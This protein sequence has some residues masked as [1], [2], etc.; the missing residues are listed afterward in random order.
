F[1][2]YDI[3]GV[4]GKEFLIDQTYNLTKAIITYFKKNNPEIQTIT[5]ARDGRN[6]SEL[7]K[8]QMLNA[9]TDLGLNVLDI[10]ICPTPTF[11]FSLFNTNTTS[12]LMITASHNPAEYNGIKI[13]LDKK[14]VWGKQ[15]QEIKNIYFE[16]SFFED[17]TN[18][19]GKIN[20]L[21]IIP[22]YINWLTNHF[23]HLKNYDIN[24]V[25]DCGNAVGGTVLPE[26]I[27][28]MNW[29]NV[30]LLFAELDGNFPNH[31]AD[32]T[33]EKNMQHV[34]K[35]LKDNKQIEL[36]L[37][38]DGDCDR[39]SPMTKN[40]YL[41]PGDQLLAIFAKKVLK[42]FPGA[43]IVFDIKA[44]SSL[45]DLLK[46]WNAK[47]HICPS[48]HSL[49]KKALMDT[50]SKLAGELSCHFFF[51]DKYFGYD[52]GIYSILRLFEILKEENKSLDELIKIFP[53]KERSPEIR[54]RC[55]ESEKNNIVNHVKSIF[56]KKKDSENIIIDGL[57]A[58]IN[59]SLGL[60]RASNTQP[61]ICLR[62]ESETKEGL[63]KVKNDFYEALKPYFDK[64]EL[65]EKI[66]L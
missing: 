17:K 24:A 64:K 51:N 12:G 21:E 50:K 14:S 28:K 19:K 43:G 56:A 32:P 4:V 15:I 22:Q 61:V 63:K 39:M 18:K 16:K 52:D 34:K 30:K 37:G 58:Q 60:I 41:V 47:D 33:V 2:E 44:S 45:I 5:V 38:L 55:K 13:C 36:G 3:R 40:G 53:N 6:H 11:Y 66:E 23:E 8:K 42:D 49:V 57:R 27:K 59:N 20:S 25:I 26:L 9:I 35:E 1:R 29:K 7:I 62:F 46:K 31:E 54:I 10:G 48:G 65:K